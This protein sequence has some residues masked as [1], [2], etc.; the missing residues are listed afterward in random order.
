MQANPLA[1]CLA[2]GK[3]SININVNFLWSDALLW[4][5]ILTHLLYLC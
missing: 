3:Y 4:G 1:Q 5:R 2:H